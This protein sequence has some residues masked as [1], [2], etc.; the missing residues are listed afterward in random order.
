MDIWQRCVGAALVGTAR[1]TPELPQGEGVLAEVVRQIDCGQPERALLGAVG[2]IAL[3]QKVGW[4]PEKTNFPAVEPCEPEDLPC[5]SQRSEKHLCKA[6][7][8][9]PEVLP[10]LLG[11]MVASGQRVPA[12]RLPA[13]LNFGQRKKD[14]RPPIILVLGRRGRW[15]AAQN[16]RWKY[17]TEDLPAVDQTK[18]TGSTDAY[19][20][21]TAQWLS[22]ELQKSQRWDMALSRTALNRFFEAAKE[23]ANHIEL[24]RLSIA[25]SVALHPGLSPELS[26]RVKEF[27]VERSH[28]TLQT[29]LD[30]AASIVSLR[31]D[32]YQ[33][34]AASG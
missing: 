11:L 18:K 30:R 29:F 22:Q 4:R 13:L 34:F 2:A 32:I 3:H 24:S 25:L 1:Q 14:L 31:W 19:K 8:K 27:S 5:C 20:G 28:S 23:S 26:Q 33:A 16:S 7:D 10:E 15:L 21:K 12:Q 6:L 9:H 17:A